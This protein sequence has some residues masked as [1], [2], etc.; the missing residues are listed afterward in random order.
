MCAAWELVW[1]SAPAGDVSL[2]DIWL[3]LDTMFTLLL[4]YRWRGFVVVIVKVSW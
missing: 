3:L 2:K 1:S 4:V